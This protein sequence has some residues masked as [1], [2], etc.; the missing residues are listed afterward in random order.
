MKKTKS[1]RRFNPSLR[2]LQKYSYKSI[3]IIG[4]FVMI[5]LILPVMI[6]SMT[7]KSIELNQK[8]T[9]SIPQPIGPSG[10]WNMIFDDEFNGTSLNTSI[11]TPGWFG[12]GIT[13]PVNSSETNCYDSAQ[14]MQP[15]DGYLHLHLINQQASCNGGSHS[16]T[17]ALVSSNPGDRVAGHKGFQYTYGYV[18]WR[19]YL[20]PTLAGQVA[21]WPAIWSD[22][23]NWPTD[24]ENDTLEGLSGSACYHFH[25]TLGGPGGC[26]SGNHGGWHTFGSDWEPGV[27]T[28][29]YDGIRVGQITTGITSVPHY[30]IM[31]NSTSTGSPITVP[32]DMLID[33]VR[34]WQ[35][36]KNKCSTPTPT[37]TSTP[38]P[39]PSLGGSLGPNLIL[40]PVCEAGVSNWVGYQAN[41]TQN[42][43]VAHSGIASCKVAQTTGN[44]YS[45]D[46]SP[47]RVTNPQRCPVYSDLCW[48]LRISVRR[49]EGLCP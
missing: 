9:A 13:G 17:G 6:F 39:T 24:G 45:I 19:A 36:C 16:Y 41:I 26:A 12:T 14:V 3:I 7:R 8:V 42:I 28:Y 23:Q 49:I 22:G 46:A 18:E 35:P 5:I 48:L 43:S 34:V 10:S 47:D 44:L 38:R 4:F 21:N 31:N 15:G 20:P 37:T 25:S 32:T 11:W 33:Y 27:V 1:Y 30:L 40:A 29:Y 2:K